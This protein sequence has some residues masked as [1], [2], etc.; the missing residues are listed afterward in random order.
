MVLCGKKTNLYDGERNN[1]NTDHHTNQ[2]PTVPG[3][4]LGSYEGNEKF[5]DI[6]HDR[7]NAEN[8]PLSVIEC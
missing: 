1:I 8:I 4:L 2:V 3:V 5:H 6:A 7:H